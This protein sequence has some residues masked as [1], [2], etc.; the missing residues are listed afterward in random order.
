MQS[1]VFP[2]IT[3][4]LERRHKELPVTSYGVANSSIN[5]SQSAKRKAVINLGNF[6]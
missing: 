6:L 3:H 1:L 2:A 4:V 5:K